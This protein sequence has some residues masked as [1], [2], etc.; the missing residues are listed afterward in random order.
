MLSERCDH[1][2]MVRDM[3]VREE[4]DAL[5]LIMSC[6]GP[7][8]R[9]WRD[10]PQLAAGRKVEVQPCDH[11]ELCLPLLAGHLRQETD[12]TPE[13][14]ERGTQHCDTLSLLRET[15]TGLRICRT[16]GSQVY[17]ILSI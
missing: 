17:V 4:F 3:T 14:R 11:M 16:V 2:G 9:P 5:L 15:H 12:F 6:A 8:A 7:R 1:G 13:S 10:Q